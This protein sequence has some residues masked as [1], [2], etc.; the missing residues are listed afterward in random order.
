MDKTRGHID[1][2]QDGLGK[3]MVRKD[4]DPVMTPSFMLT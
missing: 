1:R 4:G 2:P 3:G